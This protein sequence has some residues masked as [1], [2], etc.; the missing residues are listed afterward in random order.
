[1]E[2]DV[3]LDSLGSEENYGEVF[4]CKNC[5]F[6]MIYNG[7]NYCPGCGTPI[8]WKKYK[9]KLNYGSDY[10]IDVTGTV[11]V[12]DIKNYPYKTSHLVIIKQADNSNRGL[13]SFMIGS[14][15]TLP[16]SCTSEAQA[17]HVSESI[18]NNL[19]S[20]F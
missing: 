20:G 19:E 6:S 18:R 10:T 9:R 1:M 2:I 14:V 7:F 11:V 3:H 16:I 15:A 8:L 12:M 5:N 4:K 13:T 17:L